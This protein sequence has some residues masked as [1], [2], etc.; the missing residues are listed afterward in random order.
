MYSLLY[1]NQNSSCETRKWELRDILF[2]VRAD[3]ITKSK[4]KSQAVVPPSGHIKNPTTSTLGFSGRLWGPDLHFGPQ[5]SSLPSFLWSGRSRRP[6][7]ASSSPRNTPSPGFLVTSPP[8]RRSWRDASWRSSGGSDP[9]MTDPGT[10]RGGQNNR[11]T[12]NK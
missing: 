5:H 7:P 2:T 6:P 1:L 4:T 12:L 10:L 3:C 9:P 11:D 8:W